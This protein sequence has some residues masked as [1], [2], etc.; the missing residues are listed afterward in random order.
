[1]WFADSAPIDHSVPLLLLL[2]NSFASL[3]NVFLVISDQGG[4]PTN[5]PTAQSF[6]SLSLSVSVC[7]CKCGSCGKLQK[8]QKSVHMYLSCSC[9]CCSMWVCPLQLIYDTA[10]TNA[11]L[12]A[13][14]K[15]WTTC[16]CVCGGERERGRETEC[17]CTCVRSRCPVFCSVPQT[18]WSLLLLPRADGPGHVL[19]CLPGQATPPPL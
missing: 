4:V 6:L 11:C 12:R 5:F 1:M 13:L 10:C 14:D 19:L 8:K 15:M 7:V 16:V 2:H 17:V 18:G 3:M 9:A